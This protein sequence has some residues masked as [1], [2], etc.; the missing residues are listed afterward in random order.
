MHAADALVYEAELETRNRKPLQRPIED[1]PTATW[2]LRVR[3]KHRLLYGVYRVVD[4][5]K[6]S[7]IVEILRVIIKETETTEKALRRER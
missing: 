1:L 7:R 2:E 6:E 3:S 5:E 4:G